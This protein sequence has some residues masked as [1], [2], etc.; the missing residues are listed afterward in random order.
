MLSCSSRGMRDR[1]RLR[2]RPP[3]RP[4]SRTPESSRRHA[5]GRLDASSVA[6]ALGDKAHIDC[7]RGSA[8]SLSG[9][10]RRAR[11]ARIPHLVE[12]HG[13]WVAHRH[14]R[15]V[16][17]VR[18]ATERARST[19][20]ASEING[21]SGRGERRGCHL[22]RDRLGT[23][24]IHDDAGVRPCQGVDRHVERRLPGAPCKM[25]RR[26]SNPVAA[27]PRHR[28]IRV[29][30]AH[31]WII[32][33]EGEHPVTPNTAM[34]ITKRDRL[35]GRELHPTKRFLLNNQEVVPEPFILVKRQIH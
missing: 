6:A 4:R 30:H 5:R 10:P 25:Q 3:H 32:H 11:S 21:R 1:F 7:L 12:G 27:H 13:M 14:A 19:Q 8:P 18:P 33:T 15:Q 29:D 16:K 17:S 22:Y 9:E 35:H 31:R 24:A 28:A 34:P 26:T 23:R 20:G 2:R